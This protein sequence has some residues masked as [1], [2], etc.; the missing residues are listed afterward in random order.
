MSKT[1]NIMAVATADAAYKPAPAARPIPATAQMVA[2]C[3]QPGKYTLAAADYGTSTD[4][5]IGSQASLFTCPFSLIAND[6]PQHR[7]QEKA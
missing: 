4:E 7:G 2:S 5:G 3:D 6:R 1:A